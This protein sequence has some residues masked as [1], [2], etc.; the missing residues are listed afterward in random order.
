[1][2]HD[3]QWRMTALSECLTETCSGWR[4]QPEN[5]LTYLFGSRNSP[6][7]SGLDVSSF[8]KMILHHLPCW[9]VVMALNLIF[10]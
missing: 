5:T 8:S 3:E 6:L 10:Q 7:V 1:M 2:N 9:T 4:V